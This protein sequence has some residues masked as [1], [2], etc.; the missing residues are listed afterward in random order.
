MRFSEYCA[1]V[2]SRGSSSRE[3]FKYSSE[4]KKVSDPF[5]AITADGVGCYVNDVSKSKIFVGETLRTSFLIQFTS[6]MRWYISSAAHA[7][8]ERMYICAEKDAYPAV[9]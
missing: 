6:L 9:K 2:R 5:K 4:L 7:E 3:G 1:H 8:C